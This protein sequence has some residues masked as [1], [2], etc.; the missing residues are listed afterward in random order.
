MTFGTILSIRAIAIVGEGTTY[1]CCGVDSYMGISA[2]VIGAVSSEK[3]VTCGD[4]M[5]GG[6]M[7]KIATFAFRTGS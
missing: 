2:V 6:F 3:V 1:W 7:G 5:S 4:S